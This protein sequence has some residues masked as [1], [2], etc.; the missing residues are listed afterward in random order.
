[1]AEVDVMMGKDGSLPRVFEASRKI[2]EFV[3][4]SPEVTIMVLD[5]YCPGPSKEVSRLQ[6]EIRNFAQN[7]IAGKGSVIGCC[8]RV[9]MC[10]PACSWWERIPMWRSL[11]PGS[12]VH[13]RRCS[14]GGAHKFGDNINTDYIIASK[15][16]SPLI[17]EIL[18]AGGI[19]PH[20]EQKRAKA[21][22]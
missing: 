13:N 17:R 4:R 3:V 20:M 8:R 16:F 10:F 12:S 5:H 21:T 1:L 18:H 2:R 7:T 15:P 19:I 6:G 14:V 9:G 22:P 11:I